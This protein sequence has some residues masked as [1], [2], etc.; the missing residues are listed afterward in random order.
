MIQG[1]DFETEMEHADDIVLI[2]IK[3]MGLDIVLIY[4]KYMGLELKLL[5]YFA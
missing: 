1:N 5:K 2:Y 4:I 3:Y